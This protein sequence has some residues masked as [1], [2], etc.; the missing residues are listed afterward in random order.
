MIKTVNGI[1][2]EY[3][4]RQNRWIYPSSQAVDRLISEFIAQDIG[5]L[6]KFVITYQETL[7]T[8]D[9]LICVYKAGDQGKLIPYGCVQASARPTLAALIPLDC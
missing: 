1:T 9:A 6:Y 4:T 2:Y 8:C 5:Q 3:V 7:L